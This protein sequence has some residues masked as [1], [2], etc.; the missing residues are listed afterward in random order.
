M[1]IYAAGTFDLSDDAGR[2]LG[3]IA[4]ITAAVD[5]SDRAARDLGQV[6][7]LLGGA[8]DNCGC[9]GAT[10]VNPAADAELARSGNLP[11]G[12]YEVSIALSSTLASADL[13]F[14]V[15][16]ASDVAR[17]TA[18]LCLD[19]NTPTPTMTI[20]LAVNEEVR[21]VATAAITGTCTGILSWRRIVGA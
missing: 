19:F 20:P 18:A 14:Q 17:M 7:A 21:I 8:Y 2:L 1:R 16:N 5:I 3:I 9:E 4:S 13:R 10:V 12:K 15:L 6:D 11:E